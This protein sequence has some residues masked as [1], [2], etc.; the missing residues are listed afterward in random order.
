MA[1]TLIPLLALALLAGCDPDASRDPAAGAA[2]DTL[3]VE[4]ALLYRERVALP[5]G[6]TAE[7]A[8]RPEDDADAAPLADTTF[9]TEAN[10]PLPFRLPVPAGA[11]DT[12]RAY[13][14]TARLAS[15]DGRMRWATPAP[16]AVLTRGAPAQLEVVL[17]AEDVPPAPPGPEPWREA[18]ERGV[19]FRGIGQEP[20]WMVDVYGPIRAPER[21]VFTAAYGEER[22]SFETVLR[23]TDGDGNPRLQ[24]VDG[25]HVALEV[26]IVDGVC[27]D[28]MSGEVFEAAV[29]VYF[30]DQTFDGCGRSLL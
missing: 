9:A 26:I 10:V 18:R 12:T 21:L 2:P 3:F 6:S 23:D 5:P 14:L 13:V 1:R 15:A 24:A 19:S 28:I 16:L 11:V 8:I 7:V 4:G 30:G 17:Y 25:E 27:Q 20:G 22:H 29:R